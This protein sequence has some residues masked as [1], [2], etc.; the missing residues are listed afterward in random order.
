MIG[1]GALTCLENSNVEIGNGALTC[2]ENSNVDKD[3]DITC[4]TL[5]GSIMIP[6]GCD[7]VFQTEGGG[8]LAVEGKMER[9]N[10][11]CSG[12]GGGT[13]DSADGDDSSS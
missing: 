3:L 12:G 13:D 11:V 10:E 4:A 9:Y 5:C 1:N 7:T 2:L 8:L 6:P